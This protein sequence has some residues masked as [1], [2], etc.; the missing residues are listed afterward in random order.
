V[1]IA[2]DPASRLLP[3]VALL[4]DSDKMPMYQTIIN[5][6]KQNANGSSN[7]IARV[8]KDGAYG[9]SLEKFTMENINLNL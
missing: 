2:A 3:T 6:C 5:L 4:R 9:I 7:K 1:V 8:L